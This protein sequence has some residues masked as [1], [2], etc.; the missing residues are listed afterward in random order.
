MYH[1][2]TAARRASWYRE[3]VNRIRI[4]LVT[5]I[6]AC[7]GGTAPV[8]SSGEGAAA[9]EARPGSI[10]ER[11][12]WRDASRTL[13]CASVIV[14]DLGW[15]VDRGQYRARGCGWELIYVVACDRE[16]SCQFV[17]AEE[18]VSP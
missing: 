15:M 7:G 10:T 4:L 5:A 11:A 2:A 16:D 9:E 12:I 6:A 14:E 18:G 3:A 8:R 17:I 13:R 1:R